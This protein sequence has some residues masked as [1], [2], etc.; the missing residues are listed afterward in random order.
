MPI[1]ERKNLL[2][3]SASAQIQYNLPRHISIPLSA[4]ATRVVKVRR[5]NPETSDEPGTN[6]RPG[7]EDSSVP[8][9]NS[10]DQFSG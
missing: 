1:A 8:H 7:R 5:D 4:E 3:P 9:Y 10:K 2:L 6:A